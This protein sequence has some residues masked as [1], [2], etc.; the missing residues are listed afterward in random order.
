M[1]IFRDHFSVLKFRWLPFRVFPLWDLVEEKNAFCSLL[2]K[3]WKDLLCSREFSLSRDVL[4]WFSNRRRNEFRSSIHQKRIMERW[5]FRGDEQTKT[6]PFY[7]SIR[8]R[9]SPVSSDLIS[10]SPSLFAWMTRA[11]P[12]L[13]SKITLSRGDQ[14][15]IEITL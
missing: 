5:I 3:A 1:I 12:D 9:V 10:E 6:F 4:R 2:F 7:V 8:M 13:R 14:K 15:K 11:R